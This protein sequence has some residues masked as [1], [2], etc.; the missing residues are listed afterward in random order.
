MLYPSVVTAILLVLVTGTPW[1]ARLYRCE[2][3]QGQISFTGHGC[4]AQHQGQLLDDRSRIV[5][6]IAAPAEVQPKALPKPES[7]RQSAEIVVVG[8]RDDGC[9]NL[10]SDRQRRNAR[11]KQLIPAGMSLQD[12]ERALGSPERI[13]RVNGRTRYYYSDRRGNKRQVSFDQNGCSEK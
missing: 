8:E 9:G 3:N 4:P 5:N 7:S 1:A 12:V 13:S 11:I 2:D 6:S 10:L